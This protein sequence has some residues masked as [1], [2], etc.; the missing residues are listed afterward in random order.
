MVSEQRVALVIGNADYASGPLRNPVNDARA[1]ANAL[2]GCRF[3]V[4]E[5]LNVDRRETRRSI[6]DFAKRIKAGGVGLFYYAGHGVQVNGEN[7]LVPIGAEMR[8][9]DEV[10]DDC[11]R[12]SFVLEKMEDADNRVNIVILDAC[13]N[14]PYARS[15]RSGTRGLARMDAAT[16]S[17]LAYS[18]APGDV[19]ADGEG[20]NGLYTSKLLMHINTPGLAIEEML[21]EVRKD[22]M[23]AS[24]DQQVPWESSSLTGDFAF[25]VGDADPELDAARRENEQL[26]QQLLKM[27]IERNR[28]KMQDV[29]E[30]IVH[31]YSEETLSASKREA[32]DMV[33]VSDFG[34]YIDKYEVTNNEYAEFVKSTNHRGPECNP[35]YRSAWNTWLGNQPP[36]GYGNHPVVGVTW[37]DARTYCRWAGKR[38]PTAKEWQQACQGT[39]GRDYPWGNS[40]GTGNAN[41][42]HRGAHANTTP[43]G[44]FP[45]G[46]SPYGAMDMA[47][48]VFEWTSTTW[49]SDPADR[50]LTSG[51][52]LFD[53]GMAQCEALYR[54]SVNNEE[55]S[56]MTG[57][58]CAK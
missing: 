24:S 55:W 51:S 46:A 4:I 53:R 29:V 38:L 28:N 30:D 41:A 37:E 5:K 33:D 47:G 13:R 10:D 20:G 34:F 48:N 40:F 43:V 15:F 39:D 2:R 32:G 19:A 54:T 16:G 45:T 42:N 35:K 50:T 26:R 31:N 1:M 3:D 57:F 7:Y 21:K 23:A 56:Y 6:R 12:A 49:R 44:S 27:R 52:Y 25:V 14:N 58:R 8:S 9:E 17:I 18:T 36:Q 11:V 22:V